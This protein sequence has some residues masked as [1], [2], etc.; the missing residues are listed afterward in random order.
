MGTTNSFIALL[1]LGGGG[2]GGG[3]GGRGGGGGGG[4]GGGTHREGW[5]EVYFSTKIVQSVA[6]KSKLSGAL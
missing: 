4:G 3:G 2:G 6:C 5:V 1:I